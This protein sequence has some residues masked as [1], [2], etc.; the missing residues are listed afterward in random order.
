MR[1][2]D[3]DRRVRALMTAPGHVCFSLTEDLHGCRSG[4]IGIFHRKR[5]L[6]APVVCLGRCRHPAKVQSREASTLAVSLRD[7]GALWV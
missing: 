5:A 7:L 3:L 2:E 6:S 4:V 1:A